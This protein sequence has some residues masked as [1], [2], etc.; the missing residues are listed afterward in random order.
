MS[1]NQITKFG[2][3]ELANALVF[4]K[5][6]KVLCIGNVQMGDEGAEMIA[7]AVRQR[8]S[9]IELDLQNNEIGKGITSFNYCLNRITKLDLYKNRIN[10]ATCEQL[11][12][13]LMNNF[14]VKILNLRLNEIEDA[15]AKAL[16]DMLMYNSTLEELDLS[17]NGY[18]MGKMFTF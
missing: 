16:G 10:D 5:T 3:Q 18:E 15:G 17:G 2:I 9:Y 14:S 4:N 8:N 6:L 1:N 12:R 11:A 13:G 7:N